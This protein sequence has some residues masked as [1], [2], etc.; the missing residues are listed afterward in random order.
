[1]PYQ[2]AS[3]RTRCRGA[4]PRRWKTADISRRISLFHSV[5]AARK[6][7]DLPRLSFVRDVGRRLNPSQAADLKRAG[8]VDAAARL[9]NAAGRGASLLMTMQAARRNGFGGGEIGK[10]HV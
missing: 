1:M 3:G 10:A 5:G 6:G 2:A 8:H 4:L 9:E 7:L